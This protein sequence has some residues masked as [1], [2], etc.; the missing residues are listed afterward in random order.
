M[1]F[2]I[3]TPPRMTGRYTKDIP[4]IFDWCLTLV[5]KLRASFSHIDDSQIVSLSCDKLSGTINLD[6]VTISNGGSIDISSDYF[7]I[8]N[9]SGSQYIELKDNVINIK[10][11]I[12]S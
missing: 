12:I 5:K 8:S 11:N 6:N 10:A 1:N 4:A 7:R 3:R 9:S 2:D